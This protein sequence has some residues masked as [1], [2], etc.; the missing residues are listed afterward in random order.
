MLKINEQNSVF[1]SEE[2]LLFNFVLA[3]ILIYFIF[4]KRETI[5]T[6][7]VSLSAD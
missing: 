5:V 2:I 3:F 4:L 7:C 1:V 6:F